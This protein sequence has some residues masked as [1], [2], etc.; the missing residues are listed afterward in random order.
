MKYTTVKR[1][2]YLLLLLTFASPVFGQ[3]VQKLLYK[4]HHGTSSERVQAGEELNFYYQSESKDSLR[5]IGEEL[6]FYG[7]DEHYY[8]AIE[9]GKMILAQYYVLSG[10]TSEGIATLKSLLP[11]IQERND[12][13]QLCIASKTIS[14]GYTIEKDAKSAYYWAKKAVLCSS[15]LLNPKDRTSGLIA[16]AETYVL[17]DETRM[18]IQIYEKYVRLEKANDNPRGLSAA[19]ARLGDIYRLS[20]N[21]EKAHYYFQLSF[22]EAQ[23]AQLSTPI[24]HALNNLAILFFEQ[25]D[26]IQSRLYFVKALLLRK[27]SN[28][29]KS[30]SESYYNLGDYHF[31]ID[32]L[33]KATYWY[34]LSYDF[35]ATNNL[36]NEQKD[37]L[38]ALA[39]VAKVQND[40]KRATSLLEKYIAINNQIR[41][42]ELADDEEIMKLQLKLNQIERQAK[43]NTNETNTTHFQWEWLLIGG[44]SLLLVVTLRKKPNSTAQEKLIE[45]QEY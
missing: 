21:L 31:Y 11:A 6:F 37:A 23:K 9:K 4:F 43:Y 41:I 16:L 2:I 10:K 32:Q 20:G 33:D 34:Q 30:I 35:S 5:V 12:M 40:Y 1:N 42:Q 25:G 19:Y 18:A 44:L 15:T 3:Q 27:K 28:D 17:R 38:K 22:Q 24:G 36:K 13:K 7:I 14:E 26:T 45:K 8:P 39:E 29:I